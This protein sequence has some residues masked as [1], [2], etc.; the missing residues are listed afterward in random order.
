MSA[1]ARAQTASMLS[2]CLLRGK[3]RP[4]EEV[5]ESLPGSGA[6][7]SRGKKAFETTWTRQLELQLLCTLQG[8]R[9][10]LHPVTSPPPRWQ[11]SAATVP[12]A[13]NRESLSWFSRGLMPHLCP[14]GH[15]QLGG[16]GPRE[17]G[18]RLPVTWSQGRS[19]APACWPLS[20]LQGSKRAFHHVWVSGCL[21]EQCH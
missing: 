14:G 19:R 2:G 10:R 11:G 6:L 9:P 5:R 1:C 20:Q 4:G 15:L 12:R 18:H 16:V 17:V 21:S 13:R 8:H 7:A 3:L